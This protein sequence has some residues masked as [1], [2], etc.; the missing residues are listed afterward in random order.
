LLGEGWKAALHPDDRQRV[1]S[2]WSNAVET[3]QPYETE[4][5]LRRF[6]GSYHW[7][8]ARAIPTRNH[9]GHI[10]Q[11][12]GSSTDV[13]DLKRTGAA[14]KRSNEELRQFAYVAAH[15]LQEPL[16]NISNSVGLVKRLYLSNLDGTAIKWIDFSVESALRM[17]EMV[18]DLLIYSRAVDTAELAEQPVSANEGVQAALA[19]LSTAISASKA[20]I[21]VGALPRV[22]ISETHLIQIFQNLI[23]NALKYRKKDVRPEIRISAS[24]HGLDWHFSVA[25]NGIGFDPQYSEKIFGVFKRLHA[26]NEYP[27]NGIGLAICTRIVSHYGGRIWADSQIGQGSVFHFS[28]PAQEEAA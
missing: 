3:G 4:Y 17:H 12:L 20:I 18:K 21:E 26:R 13:D 7:F 19:N 9:N 6:D 14:L 27:G 2:I 25:D 23:A 5:R 24:Q 22:L 16:R 28:L 10:R 15:D 8:V 11:W 1:E